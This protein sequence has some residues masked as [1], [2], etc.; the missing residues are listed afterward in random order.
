MADASSKKVVIAAL[1]ANFLIAVSKFAA[2]AVSG[3]IAMLAEAFHSVADTGNQ[4]LLLVGF[5][6][7]KRPA[8]DLH[9][10]GYGMETYFWTFVVGVS[11]FTIGAAVS[12]YEG[13]QR[14]V[15][16]HEL[17][18]MT[19]SY[20]VLSLGI[21]FEGT[22]WV[23]AVRELRKK[24]GTRTL[25]QEIKQ[26][27]SPALVVVFLED[28]AALI[29]LTIALVGVFIADM[30]GNPLFDGIASI[31]IGLLLALV[32]FIVSYESK[33][34]LLGEGLGKEN[35]KKVRDAIQSVPEVT[36]CYQLLTMYLSPENVLVNC[37]VNLIDGL[38]TDGVEEVID[39]IEQAIQ[40]ALP[41]VGQ[42]FVEIEDLK[43][44]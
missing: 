21:L 40:K 31:A 28:S 37:Q 44:D 13:I 3:S 39:R 24:L 29:G 6:A 22:S 42:I 34:L 17:G 14:L 33:S 2:A 5:K 27:K 4:V 15:H 9:P 7:S 43:K 36:N 30:T 26:T 11:M 35:L 1:I 19:I 18:S 41:W 10:F 12:I 32:A 20:V 23:I 16:P 8:D 38:D 25:W